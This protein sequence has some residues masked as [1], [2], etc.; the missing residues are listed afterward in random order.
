MTYSVGFLAMGL[1]VSILIAAISGM[2]LHEASTNTSESYSTSVKWFGG[3]CMGTALVVLIA[4]PLVAG[5]RG[6]KLGLFLLA[7][8]L[9]VIVISVSGMAIQL[10]HGESSE[11]YKKAVRTVSGI[12]LG[13]SIVGILSLFLVAYK[14]HEDGNS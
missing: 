5:L 11:A 4:S 7:V 12:S 13:L 9:S 1:V 6:R 8:L 2:A 10:S 3:I 14:V